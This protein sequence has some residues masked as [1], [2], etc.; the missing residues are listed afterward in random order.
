M[1]RP[2]DEQV[3]YI[4]RVDYRNDRRVFGIRRRDRRSHMYM[5]GKTGTGKSTL[6]ANMIRQDIV[7]GQGLAVLDP[8][9]ELIEQALQCVPESRQPDL[10]YFNVPDSSLEL[11]FNPLD[12]VAPQDRALTASDLID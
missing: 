7:A 1:P 2:N 5:V 11:G 10:V 8:H 4:A 9:G 6:L 3:T 12:Q